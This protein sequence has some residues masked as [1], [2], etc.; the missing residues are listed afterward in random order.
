MEEPVKSIQ[1]IIA[2]AEKLTLQ[3]FMVNISDCSAI[4][5]GG[6]MRVAACFLVVIGIFFLV[7]PGISSAQYISVKQN[8]WGTLQYTKN[9]VDFEE[10]GGGWKNLLAETESVEEA[11]KNIRQSRNI[12]YASVVFGVGG[13]AVLGYAAGLE[14]ENEEVD[15]AYWIVGGGMML[16]SIICE[17]VG[18]HKL[19]KGLL[20]YNKHIGGYSSNY[21]GGNRFDIGFTGNGVSVSYYFW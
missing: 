18:R 3:A 16:T 10:F 21:S 1:K 11:H 17:V 4:K 20:A 7:L 12:H 15:D 14:S 8:F 19:D 6:I 13:G 5:K 2:E 9:G